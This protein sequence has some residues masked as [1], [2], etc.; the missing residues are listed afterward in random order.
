[1]DWH[2]EE[3]QFERKVEYED[4]DELVLVPGPDEM[5]KIG[6][7]VIGEETETNEREVYVYEVEKETDMFKIEMTWIFDPEDE[8]IT[9]EEMEARINPIIE[10]EG[11]HEVTH[12]LRSMNLPPVPGL[13]EEPSIDRE[14][15]DEDILPEE[16]RDEI[17]QD[18][19]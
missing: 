5:K 8:D 1:M 2:I 10:W 17:E 18:N 11:S 16:L 19:G 14:E 15:L 3:C 13:L 6:K 7:R 12:Y 9:D 4:K